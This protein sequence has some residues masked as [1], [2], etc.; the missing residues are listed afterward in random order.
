[1]YYGPWLSYCQWWCLLECCLYYEGPKR[2]ATLQL[3]MCFMSRVKVEGLI[4]TTDQQF[5]TRSKGLL[6]VLT[7]KGDG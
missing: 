6:M 4:Q 7:Q 3:V 1:M 2:A 5:S